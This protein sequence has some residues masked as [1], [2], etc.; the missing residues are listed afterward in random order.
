MRLLI[1]RSHVVRSSFHTLE[2]LSDGAF[3]VIFL[4]VFTVI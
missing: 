2:G 1:M 4:H 3:D